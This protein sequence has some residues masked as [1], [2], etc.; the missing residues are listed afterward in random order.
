MVILR[1]FRTLL[2][3]SFHSSSPLACLRIQ[4]ALPSAWPKGNARTHVVA[5][6]S[7]ADVVR[8]P[9]SKDALSAR[10]RHRHTAFKVLAVLG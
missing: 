3:S 4:A 8:A 9:K 1:P 6:C 2:R 7:N 10:A 5:A